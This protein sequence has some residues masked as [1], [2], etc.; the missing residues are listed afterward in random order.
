M[1]FTVAL[2]THWGQKTMVNASLAQDRLVWVYHVQRLWIV[3]ATALA[4]TAA[5]GAVG[6][7]CILRNGEDR[8]LTFW[9]IVRATRNSELDAVIEGDKRGDAG[10]ATMLQYTVQERDLEANTSG[11]FMLIRLR[12]KGSN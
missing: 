10:K 11:V 6:F 3:Y 4:V 2:M 9:D 5:C 8:D 12:R 1:N 7:A